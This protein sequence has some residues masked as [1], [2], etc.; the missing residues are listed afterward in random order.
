MSLTNP[1]YP[2]FIDWLEKVFVAMRD[3]SQD[4]LTRATMMNLDEE[5]RLDHHPDNV[6]HEFQKRLH[7]KT[8]PANGSELLDAIGEAVSKSPDMHCL[9]PVADDERGDVD[10][11]GYICVG[12]NRLVRYGYVR[13]PYDADDPPPIRP[14]TLLRGYGIPKSASRP[15]RPIVWISLDPP[16]RIDAAGSRD[17]LGLKSLQD[18]WL[19]VIEITNPGELAS[20]SIP[21]SLDAEAAPPFAPPPSKMPPGVRS[22]PWGFTRELHSDQLSCREVIARPD[23][24]P[25]IQQAQ[26]MTNGWVGNSSCEYLEVR[27][28]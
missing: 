23:H 5:E 9:L 11:V 15:G 22:G 18:T 4:R 16:D 20:L 8:E 2:S 12:W 17:R 7:E 3:P 10:D 25:E 24:L 13:D 14:L 19:M 28:A 6:V 27:I 1:I 26:A 21:T